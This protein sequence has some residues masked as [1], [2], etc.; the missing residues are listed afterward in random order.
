MITISYKEN[1]FSFDFASLDYTNPVKNQHAYMLEG[2]D[3]DW[4]NVGNVRTANYTD[5]EPGEY[6]FRVKG[7]N[8]DGVWNEEGTSVKLTITPPWWQTW[9]FKSCGLGL[10]LFTVGFG[11][12]KRINKLENEK[13][14]QVEFSRKLLKSQEE[15]RKRLANELHDSV[16]HDILILK[17]SAVIAMSKTNEEETKAALNEIS[18]QSS[19]TLNDVRNISYNLH[20][21]QLEALGLTKA[22]KSIVDKASKST[23]VKFIYEGD[24]IDRIF[25]EE[26]EVYIYRIV[27]EAVNN[28]IK[29]SLATEAII[30]ISRMDEFVY[31]N[32]SD[33]GRG[34]SKQSVA[35]KNSLG[36]SGIAERV[37]LLHGSFEIE[38]KM[39]GGTVLETNIPVK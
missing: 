29:H 6:I 1:F 34:F 3:K 26:N 39:N 4:I 32:I 36:L 13:L 18:E 37:R 17:N 19:S 14:V 23:D 12:K 8:N 20:P 35:A 22:I 21:Q 25:T 28:I 30:K 10:I 5:I 33:N 2:I 11:Y 9:W 27:Q 38:T 16:A 31:L 7:S 24:I 15:E